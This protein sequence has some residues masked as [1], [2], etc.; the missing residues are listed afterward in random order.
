[1][2]KLPN[3]SLITDRIK[4]SIEQSRQHHFRAAVLLIDL[5]RYKHNQ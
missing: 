1:M 5:D 3:R 2:T 4:L